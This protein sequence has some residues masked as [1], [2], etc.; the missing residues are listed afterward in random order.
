MGTLL[1][2]DLHSG[3]EMGSTGA[4]QENVALRALRWLTGD[5]QAEAEG[6]ALGYLAE[7]VSKA[8]GT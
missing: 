4:M 8:E 6:G 3:G 1:P 7:R 5:V 2:W